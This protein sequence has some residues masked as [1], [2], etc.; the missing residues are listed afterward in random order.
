MRITKSKP[1]V[2]MEDNDNIS[3]AWFLFSPVFFEC[4]TVA[5]PVPLDSLS[6]H[7]VYPVPVVVLSTVAP[8]I[9]QVPVCLFGCPSTSVQGVTV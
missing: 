2:N 5:S 9:S 8:H 1:R 7:V 4:P 6:P 3:I